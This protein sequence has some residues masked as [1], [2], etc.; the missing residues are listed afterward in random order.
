MFEG[1][2]LTFNPGLTNRMERLESFTDV[3]TVQAS[4][5][6]ADV[7]LTTRAEDGEGPASLTLVDPDGNQV[8]VDQFF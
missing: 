1:N 3:R 6:A 8:L 5:D 7:G 4:L 2:I